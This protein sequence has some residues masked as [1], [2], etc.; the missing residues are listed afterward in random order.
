[1]HTMQELDSASTN[2]EPQGNGYLDPV[3]RLEGTRP[4]KN[5]QLICTSVI[6]MLLPLLAQIGHAH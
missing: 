5:L 4:P 2:N 6:G 3:E 1:M